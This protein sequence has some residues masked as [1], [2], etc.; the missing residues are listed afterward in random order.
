[1]SEKLKILVISNTYP[2][3]KNDNSVIF[4]KTLYQAIAKTGKASIEIIAA[5]HVALY[6]KDNLHDDLSIF[7]FQYWFRKYQRLTYGD[8]I[9]SNLNK[10][11]FLKLL[12]PLFV[13][14][15]FYRSFR[16]IWSN[17]PDI[18]HAHWALPCGLVGVFLSKMFSIPL[19]VTSHGGDVYGLNKGLSHY[20]LKFVYHNAN[21]IN[22]V[23]EVLAEEIVKIGDESLPIEILSMGVDTSK[24][25][26]LKNAKAL[27]DIQPNKQIVLFVG[28]LSEVKGVKNLV[29][30]IDILVNQQAQKNIQTLII[31]HG[32]LEEELKR[33]SV[34]HNLTAY[35][36][37]LGNIPNNDL[38]KYYSAA[39]VLTIPSVESVGGKEGFPVTM[40][41]GLICHCNVV[42]SKIG[43]MKNLKG[44]K[45][46]TLVEQND[47]N[48]LAQAIK[49]YT[50]QEKIVNLKLTKSFKIE[51]VANKYI[52]IYKRLLTS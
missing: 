29:M 30:A 31:G 39:D 3:H 22:A 23:S 15:M 11:R 7:R 17:R 34:E 50:T 18:I 38:Y 6:E 26:Y 8:A 12:I 9:L 37:F 24:F 1:M 46:I 5:D 43:G 42:A 28:R 16:R 33:L 40:M 14:A 51:N 19:V 10:N 35:I 45:Q 20:L 44:Y 41:E 27:L 2:L 25:Y 4:I 13:L 36:N 21:L 32:N 49:N 52:E 48:G 47:I